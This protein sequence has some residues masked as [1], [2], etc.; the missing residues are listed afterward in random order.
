MYSLPSNMR[1]S[2]G[3]VVEDLHSTVPKKTDINN[4]RFVS[5]QHAAKA[6]WCR[7]YGY[8]LRH[9]SPTAVMPV[10]IKQYIEA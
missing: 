8:V 4:S 3:S 10:M 1:P 9:G 6:E 2:T 7:C 5:L